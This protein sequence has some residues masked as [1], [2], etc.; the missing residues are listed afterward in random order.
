MSED[1]SAHL[2]GNLTS[3]IDIRGFHSKIHT[4]QQN[5][6]SHFE[7]CDLQSP[8]FPWHLSERRARRVKADLRLKLDGKSPYYL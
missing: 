2:Y 3:N 4:L 6:D 1:A 7:S 5:E 8:V